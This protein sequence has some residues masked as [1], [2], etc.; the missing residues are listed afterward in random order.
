[1]DKG[2]LHLNNA[3]GNEIGTSQT[4]KEV[5]EEQSE[6]AEVEVNIHKSTHILKELV[7]L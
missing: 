2:D 6:K 5:K 1:M 7:C 3:A 4:V